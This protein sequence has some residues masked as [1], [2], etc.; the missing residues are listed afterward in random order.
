MCR[1]CS[2]GSGLPREAIHD[3]KNIFV[4]YVCPR[5]RQQKLAGYRPEIFRD[6]NYETDEDVEPEDDTFVGGADQFCE[7]L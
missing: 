4:A 1:S 7:P 3:A 6:P 5:C 2:C